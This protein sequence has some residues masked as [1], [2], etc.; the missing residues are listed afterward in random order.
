[1]PTLPLPCGCRAVRVALTL[2]MLVVT[3]AASAQGIDAAA[4]AAGLPAASTAVRQPRTETFHG[5]TLVD[6]YR[7]LEDPAR[8]ETRAWLDGQGR[9]AAT[10]LAR[11][12]GREALARRITTLAESAGDRI[13]DLWR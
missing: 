2:V 7:Y 8:P 13:N 9:H 3:A 1:M 12:A 11:I 10:T 6:D 5:R 4:Q